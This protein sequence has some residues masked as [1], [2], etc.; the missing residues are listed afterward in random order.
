MPGN[1]ASGWLAGRWWTLQRFGLTPRKLLRRSRNPDAH[2]VLLVSVPKSGTHLLE[3]ALCL[4]PSLYRR[5]APTLLRRSIDRRWGGLDGL[6][7]RLR[8]GQVAVA[9][10]RFREDYPEVLAR[11]GV[12]TLFMVR[13]P[14]DVLVS[15]V[16]FAPG[17][18]DFAPGRVYAQQPE[19]KDRI[20]TAI[21]GKPEE[22]IPS[23]ADRLDQ[24][25]GWLD[26]GALVVRFEDL[27]GASGGGDPERQV[28]LLAGIYRHIGVPSNEELLRKIQG[29]VFSSASPT[30]RSGAIGQSK[31]AFDDDLEELFQR[32][33]GQVAAAYGY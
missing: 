33:A 19:L 25:R 11:H 14:R 17:R 21:V 32:T 3:R 4:H 23:I 13:D 9:H 16:H 2:P 20:R 18:K 15:L 12:R 5:L 7:T 6:A 8:G 29:K 22:K 26:S 28:E 24:Y 30:F 10:L 27:V 1:G 31:S